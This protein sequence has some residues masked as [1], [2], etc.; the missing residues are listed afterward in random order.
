MPPTDRYPRPRGLPHRLETQVSYRLNVPL[1]YVKGELD[2]DSAGQ[3]RPVLQEELRDEPRT[4]VLDFSEL[5][6]IDSGGLS[7]IFEVV[8]TF[9]PPRWVG[10]VGSNPGVER[11]LQM[12]GLVDSDVFRVFPDLKSASVALAQ[13]EE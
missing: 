13:S 5:G 6:Y 12:T 2:H 3:L 11:L 10:V 8:K 1:V 9:R 4:L 7:L